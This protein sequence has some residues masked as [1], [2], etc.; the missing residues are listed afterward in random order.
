MKITLVPSSGGSAE[1]ASRQYLTSYL[2]NGTVAVDAGAVGL[3]APLAAQ[4][5]VRHVVVTHA[6]IDHVAS[7]P[8]FLENVY[9][10]SGDCVTVHATPPV[11]ESLRQDVFNGRLWPDFV[12]L[13]EREPPFLKLAPLEAGRPVVLDGLRVT[14]VPVN[15]VV[16][17]VGLIVEDGAGA[18]VFPSDTGPTDL[19]WD[20]ANR[21]SNVRAVFLEATFPE[22]LSRLAGVSKHLTPSL[23]A[24]EG[25]KVRGDARLYAVHIKPRFYEEVVRELHALGLPNLE[26]VVPG[27]EYD[28]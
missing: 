10:G 7:L 22:A 23:F 9:D 8:I 28:V 3:L 6:H 26:V 18:V 21:T 4:A 1:E 11:L 25:R 17:T 2:L 16:P 20:L 5:R 27:Q 24:R 13:S 12:A 19:L 14:P 15:H